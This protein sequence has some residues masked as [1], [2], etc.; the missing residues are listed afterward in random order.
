MASAKLRSQE[1]AF[2]PTGAVAGSRGGGSGFADER[3]KAQRQEDQQQAR[4]QREC[5]QWRASGGK[6]R[7]ATTAAPKPEEIA[8]RISYASRGVDVDCD[9]KA[10]S[11]SRLNG[12]WSYIRGRG[13]FKRLRG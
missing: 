6:T 1:R 10:A 3:P 8:I 4:Q 11:G 2:S 7:D 12:R 5:R 13:C 9:G